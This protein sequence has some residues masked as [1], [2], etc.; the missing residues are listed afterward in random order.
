VNAS[1]AIYICMSLKGKN[2]LEWHFIPWWE[3]K[4]TGIKASQLI[5]AIE[6]AGNVAYVLKL[7]Q[8]NIHRC[9]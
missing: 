4:T 9:L 8:D 1:E 5:S 6:E 7:Q 2:F 3:R